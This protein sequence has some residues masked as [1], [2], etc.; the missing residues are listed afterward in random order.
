MAESS[1]ATRV[2]TRI[3]EDLQKIMRRDKVEGFDGVEYK[4]KSEYLSSII[5]DEKL[6]AY[7]PP[8]SQVGQAIAKE[9]QRQKEQESSQTQK[10]RDNGFDGER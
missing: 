6:M 7:I 9:E 2:P 1:A 3:E 8:K 5:K 10:N 4:T